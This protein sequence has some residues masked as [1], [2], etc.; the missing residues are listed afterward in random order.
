MLDA[1]VSGNLSSLEITKAHQNLKD[2]REPMNLDKVTEDD[3]LNFLSHRNSNPRNI[4]ISAASFTKA[5]PN[6][7]SIDVPSKIK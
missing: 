2:M 1:L 5:R 6:F 7:R 3:T 4:E